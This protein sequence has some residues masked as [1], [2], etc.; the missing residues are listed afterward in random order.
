MVPSP[1]PLFFPLFASLS[2][3]C[4]IPPP[5]SFLLSGYIHFLS[6]LIIP[7]IPLLPLS[8]HPSCLC[9]P[10]LS[11][12]VSFSLPSINFFLLPHLLSFPIQYFPTLPAPKCTHAC[13]HTHMHFSSYAFPPPLYL[14]PVC[15]SLSVCHSLRRWQCVTVSSRA[16]P[17]LA[18]CQAHV[19]GTCFCPFLHSLR[20]YHHICSLFS[21]MR[22]A[23]RAFP[24]T[25]KIFIHHQLADTLK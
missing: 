4:L 3:F 23:C 10:S 20:Y 9:A 21:V 24:C 5:T 22:K 16:C 1:S 2:L 11:T 19:L 13:L 17:S 15:L 8:S 7:V 25:N 12:S 14:C 6:C 18:P